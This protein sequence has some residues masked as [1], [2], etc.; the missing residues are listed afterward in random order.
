M[1][2]TRA[3]IVALAATGLL[4]LGAWVPAAHS[5]A[6]PSTNGQSRPTLD[7]LVAQ[8]SGG[9]FRSPLLCEFDGELV[10]GVRRVLI[11]SR[12]LPGRAATTRLELVDIRPGPAT[13]CMDATGT[14][15]PN[16]IGSLELQRP[17]HRHPETAKRDFK[18]A[19][20][21]DKGFEYRV[22]GGTLEVQVVEVP[23]PS[24]RVLDFEGGTATLSLVF[25]ATDAALA[26]SDFPTSRKLVLT[27]KSS[28][29]ETLVLPLFDPS[30]R[31][32]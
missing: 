10:R 22:A 11:R 8:W 13:R 2:A 15:V 27:L 5:Q 17:R 7:A 28:Q 4:A 16:L 3:F 29:G 30:A 23:A 14:R 31:P 1:I 12:M 24:P 18:R 19:L 20:K 21:Q 32:E 9:D 26:L 6:R 25:P